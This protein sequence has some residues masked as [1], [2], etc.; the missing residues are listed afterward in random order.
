MTASSQS[1]DLAI[2]GAGPAGLAAG[3]LASDLG[4]TC[5]LLDEQAE[6]QIVETL[7]Q[8]LESVSEQQRNSLVD[9]ASDYSRAVMD[10]N[11]VAYWRLDDMYS[12]QVR[13]AAGENHAEYKGGVAL[14]LPGPNGAGLTLP[15]V[16]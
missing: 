15:L 1:F 12:T 9:P 16:G 11:P 13:D 10:R 14:Y 7:L 6:P 4:L 2:L 5:V 3:A 8:L